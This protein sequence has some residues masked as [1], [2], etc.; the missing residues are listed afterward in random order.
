MGLLALLPEDREGVL[1]CG[2]EDDEVASTYQDFDPQRD[3]K[4]VELAVGQKITTFAEFRMALRLYAV[5][6]KFDVKF[7]KI[8]KK[9]LTAICSQSFGWRIRVSQTQSESCLSIKTFIKDHNCTA[10]QTNHLATSTYIANRYT[11]AIKENP[12]WEF[13]SRRQTVTRE[14]VI[15]ISMQKIYRSKGRAKEMVE[16]N[17]GEQY[18]NLRKYCQLIQETNPGLVAKISNYLSEIEPRRFKRLFL[19]YEAIYRNIREWCRP[20]IGVNGTFLKE[21]Y[22]GH[23]LS[24]IGIDGNNKMFPLAIAIVEVENRDS[25]SWFMEELMGIVGPHVV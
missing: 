16:G 12:N 24:A 20:F 22:G 1:H 25:W 13:S 9:L 17:H 7:K 21:F 18:L 8:E 4:I 6:K 11:K 14:L 2:S 5:T 15:D 19:S 3:L 10:V 23:L